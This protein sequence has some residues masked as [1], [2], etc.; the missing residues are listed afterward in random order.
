MCENNS[1]EK[2]L[3]KA[4]LSQVLGISLPTLGNWI[5]K[6]ED[7]PVISVG[8]N[9][10]EWQFSA[11]K[12]LEFLDKKRSQELEELKEKEDAVKELVYKNPSLFPE[13]DEDK[14]SGLTPKEK[15]EEYK[16]REAIRKDG[17]A[18]GKLLVADDVKEGLVFSFARLGTESRS[19]FKR[20]LR[21]NG[22]PSDIIRHNLKEYNHLQ[23]K[24]VEDLQSELN[25]QK[26]HESENL[27]LMPE[28]ENH[29]AENVL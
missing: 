14:L 25:L 13:V 15:L 5:A 20:V 11:E 8:R 21:D 22:I 6:Y 28:E 2:I 3:N 18:T 12:V 16:L 23:R 29:E 24:I 1:E 26:T 27:R 7:F 4:E 17:I 9:G 19:F 10:A